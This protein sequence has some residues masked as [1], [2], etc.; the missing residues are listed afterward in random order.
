MRAVNETVQSRKCVAAII[1]S[2]PFGSADLNL[3]AVFISKLKF[4]W[5][6]QAGV[7]PPLDRPMS[8]DEATSGV[9][10]YT[11]VECPVGYRGARLLLHLSQ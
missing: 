10:A 6:G 1:L 7:Y 3:C 9:N 11:G 4:A 2:Y 8:A 5:L